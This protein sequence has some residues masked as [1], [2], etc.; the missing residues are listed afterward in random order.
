MAL[1]LPAVGYSAV[2]VPAPGGPLLAALLLSSV[3]LGAFVAWR[4]AMA[5]RR[6]REAMLGR[7]PGIEADPV[8][9]AILA[10]WRTYPWLFNMP[11]RV[12][13]AMIAA[14]AF[15]ADR[16]QIVCVGPVD[17]PDV[18]E[19]RFEPYIITAA[20]IL[21][22]RLILL[23]IA[24]ALF[25]GSL[26][27]MLYA[28]PWQWFNS[29]AMWFPLVLVLSGSLG[30]FWRATVRP[31]YVRAAPGI[32]Q[33][34]EYR[35]GRCKPVI[36]SYPMEAGT[37]VVVFTPDL[38]ER[39]VVHTVALLRRNCRDILPIGHLRNNAEAIEHIWWALLSTAPIPQ[40][41]EAELVG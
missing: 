15:P 23:L 20:E 16:A 30:W 21:G 35:L 7:Y 5:S 9:A 39:R 8:V 13:D 38:H 6:A 29:G 14:R 2:A 28:I 37:L 36:R 24:V 18:G 32:V 27:Q 40:L 25:A 22:R 12:R 3:L 17:V 4:Q 11:H 34:V 10:E 33:V 41:D 31:T 19:Y 26:L 1:A